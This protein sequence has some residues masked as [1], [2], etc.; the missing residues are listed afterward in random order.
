MTVAFLLPTP[1]FLLDFLL[2]FFF[3][4]LDLIPLDFY[5]VILYIFILP[6]WFQC[7]YGQSERFLSHI[8]PFIVVVFI[9]SNVMGFVNMFWKCFGK[10][11]CILPIRTFL[12]MKIPQS[13]LP[14]VYNKAVSEKHTEPA[15]QGRNKG[16]DRKIRTLVLYMLLKLQSA[17]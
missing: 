12:T 10:M 13:F 9:I 15:L 14:S 2:F 8:I 3:H 6:V 11:V 5:F 7:K 4:P 1:V 17:H 16:T